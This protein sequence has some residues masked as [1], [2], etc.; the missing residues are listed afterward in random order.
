VPA[1][2]GSLC[3]GTL[4]GG[5][6]R[7]SGSFSLARRDVVAHRFLLVGLLSVLLLGG[8]ATTLEN[9]K[10]KSPEEELVLTTLRRIPR[11]IQVQSVDH[12]MLSYADDLYVG[13]FHKFLGVPN[14]GGM[15]TLTKA[16]LRVVY[17]ELFEGSK[18]ASLE[19]RDFRLSVSGN[20][21]VAEGISEILLKLE[22][23][24][25]DKREEMIRN[26][27]LWRLQ[28]T[29]HGWQIKEEIYH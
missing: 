17:K 19:I 22:G 7:R 4:T 13:N 14:P 20:R 26:E 10:A 8:C 6:G 16:N 27:V 25:K 9:Y 24:K 2:R 21:A 1:L 29:P 23:S 18:G 28:K 15:N 3:D 5:M 12:I 11:G